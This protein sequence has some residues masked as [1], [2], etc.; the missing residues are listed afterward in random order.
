MNLN[1]SAISRR[2]NFL[3]NAF[4]KQE[5]SNQPTENTTSFSAWGRSF[6]VSGVTSCRFNIGLQDSDILEL[7]RLLFSRLGST[8]GLK[9]RP[10]KSIIP[11]RTGFLSGEHHWSFAGNEVST[12]TGLGDL[13]SSWRCW[14]QVFWTLASAHPL[15]LK[16][17]DCSLS[18]EQ[19]TLSR[20]R[21]CKVL[22]TKQ[23][24]L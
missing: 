16:R 5:T 1:D 10:Q 9:L 17:R 20:E 22:H 6:S 4:T 19:R 7:H 3:L 24:W 11:S 15:N 21:L 23:V 8:T 18:I 13:N 14:T 2:R 12:S